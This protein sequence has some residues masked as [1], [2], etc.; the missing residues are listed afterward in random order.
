MSLKEVKQNE[1]IAKQ[2]MMLL[3]KKR[4]VHAFLFA[5]GD[6]NARL[7]LGKAFAKAVLC[8]YAQ[9]DACGTCISCKKFEDENHLDFMYIKKPKDKTGIVVEQIKELQNRLSVMP[10]GERYCVLIENAQLMNAQVQNKLLKLLEEP[11]APVVFILLSENSDSLLPTVLSRCTCYYLLETKQFF[12]EEI[13]NIAKNF[14]ML[15]LKKADFYEKK[16]CLSFIL[17]D[18]DDARNK[19]LSF[20]D[21]FEEEL[22]KNKEFSLI[23]NGKNACQDARQY[24]KL[25]HNVAYTLKQFCLRV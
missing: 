23:I 7:E 22:L 3:E 14:V 24:L 1:Q 5:N 21:A 16:A 4:L 10:E 6:E 11:K 9:N 20:L 18:K 13:S 15:S 12:S 25:G 19:A 17:N 8:P 2:L